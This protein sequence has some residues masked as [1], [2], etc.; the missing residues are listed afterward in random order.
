MKYRWGTGARKLFPASLIWNSIPVGGLASES[1]SCR[2]RVSEF[3]RRLHIWGR[4]VRSQWPCPTRAVDWCEKLAIAKTFQVEPQKLKR[5]NIM[6]EV[7]QR[8]IG[9]ASMHI[10]VALS[11]KKA[12]KVLKAHNLFLQQTKNRPKGG[13]LCRIILE[14]VK[15]FSLFQTLAGGERKLTGLGISQNSSPNINHHLLRKNR[16]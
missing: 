15:V 13:G 5:Y 9:W 10:S 11:L 3:S 6:D 4:L 7:R 16:N 14:S 8:F 2:P 12:F 1:R